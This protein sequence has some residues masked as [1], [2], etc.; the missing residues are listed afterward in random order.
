MPHELRPAQLPASYETEPAPEC[1]EA[2]AGYQRLSTLLQALLGAVEQRWKGSVVIREG[3]GQPATVLLCRD[4]HVV[5]G[6]LPESADL[7]EVVFSL[8]A[9]DRTAQL[10]FVRNADLVGYG[11]W[12]KQG[13]LDPL[14][15]TAAV[16]RSEE[17]D[18]CVSEAIA[19]IGASPIIIRAKL[20]RDRYNF[21]MAERSVIDI[22]D[23]GPLTLSE[24]EY[25]SALERAVVERVVFTLWV[26]RGVSLAPAWLRPVSGP[27]SRPAPALDQ[28]RDDEPTAVGPTSQRST[29]IYSQRAPASGVMGLWADP[30]AAASAPRPPQG[31]AR[32]RADEL[33]RMTELLLARGHAREAVFEAQKALQLC[34]PQPAQRALYAWALYQRSGAGRRVPAHVWEHIERALLA[35]PT[36]EAALHYRDLLLRRSGIRPRAARRRSSWV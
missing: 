18:S 17:A 34:P 36:C 20:A 27:I 13:A 8:C 12:V 26:T 7:F 16:V 15:L 6:R 31:S 28:G 14:T 21:S 35:D 11:P 2:P 30:K 22:L 4:G 3:A 9:Q 23:R 29:G 19:A 10:S 32:E 33:F 5:A 24:L 1:V 25:R